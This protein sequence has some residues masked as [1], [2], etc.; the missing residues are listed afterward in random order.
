MRETQTPVAP[1]SDTEAQHIA[2]VTAGLPFVSHIITPT[3]LTNSRPMKGTR[4]MQDRSK[5]KTA[6][7]QEVVIMFT[8]TLVV[9]SGITGLV[10]W[11]TLEKEK[12]ENWVSHTNQVIE[13]L[14]RFVSDLKDAEAGQRGYF[15][16]ND[17]GYL[18]PY[19]KGKQNSLKDIQ[20][21]QDLTADNLRQQ[22]YLSL[23]LGLTNK[24]L[25]AL[26]HAIDLQQHVSKSSA[27]SYILT[28]F[29]HITMLNIQEQVEKSI[30]EE[31]KLLK[32]RVEDV[33]HASEQVRMFYLLGFLIILTLLGGVFYLINRE[34]LERQDAQ[35]RLQDS[36]RNLEGVVKERT[37]E[38]KAQL[39]FTESITSSLLEGVCRLD[40][41]GNITFINPAAETMLGQPIGSLIGIPLY[42]AIHGKKEADRSFGNDRLIF[43]VLQTGASIHSVVDNFHRTDGTEFPV[44]CTASALIEEGH[45]VGAVISFHDITERVNA[46]QA[47]AESAAQFRTLA[48]SIAQ[49]AWT[50]DAAG[51]IN[52]Y[53]QRW[54]DYTGTDLETMMAVG[55]AKFQHPD[56]LEAVSTHY[57]ETL[58]QGEAWENTFPLRGKDGQFRWFLTRALPI[59]DSAGQIIRWF[60]TNTDVTEQIETQKALEAR[61]EEVREL[62]ADLEKR[63]EERTA[64]LQATNKEL[65]AFSYSVSHDLRSPLRSIDGFSQALLEDY[66]TQLD[67]VG[68][69]YLKR[70]RMESQRMGRLIDDMLN[71]SRLTRGEMSKETINLSTMADDIVNILRQ[72]EPGRVVTTIVQPNVIAEG[73]ERLIY[74]VLQ[75]L[76]ANAWK[77]TSKHESAEIG[78]GT[79][80]D[81]KGTTV[82]WVKD[83]GAGFSM[84]YADKLFGAF[85]RLHAMNEFSGTGIGLATVQ[86]IIHRHSGHVWAESA[87][88]EGARFYFTLT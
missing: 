82:Y 12:S 51:V 56:Y 1:L 2:A 59:R 16:S 31:K 23:L 79:H 36:N 87:I 40:R 45:I 39:D 9:L 77:F 54:Y 38:I 6:I 63:V 35:D 25:D 49:L 34:M 78:F 22:T 46:Q 11:S 57:F 27:E 76:F 71:L 13:T 41:N 10:Y 47:I 30:Q 65:E 33:Q 28:G 68:Q 48:E 86:R 80:L 84:E 3:S 53:N 32:K 66:E 50:A 58:K 52:W 5:L 55:W 21:L 24:R 8:L 37:A 70:V 81:D 14:Q 26:A 62:N 73:D 85:Q 20:N 15:I 17:T 7:R 72:Q 44:L 64:Q 74:A 43:S 88:E 69:D 4:I 18:I 83:D 42:T 75:N 19:A 67:A 61:E 29:G 60:G